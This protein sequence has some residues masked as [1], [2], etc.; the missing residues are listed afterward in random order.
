MSMK[1]RKRL[2]CI[3]CGRWTSDVVLLVDGPGEEIYQGRC[4]NKNCK[5]NEIGVV[6]ARG[7]DF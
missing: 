7:V 1:P 5:L 2:K 4:K 3:E 6:Y